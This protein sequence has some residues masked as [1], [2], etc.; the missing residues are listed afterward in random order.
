MTTFF[1]KQ[2][3]NFLSILLGMM[4]TVLAACAVL[5]AYMELCLPDVTI[6]NDA[7][8]QVPLRVYTADGKLMAEYGA[9]RRAPVP[10][11]KIPKQLIE[12]VLATE[13]ARFYSHPGVDLIGI[14]RAAI[15]VVSTGRKVQGA[16]TIT[17][18]V[19]RNFF[20]TRKKTYSR[21][22][23]EILLAIKI[24]S[25]LSKEKIL[26]LYLNKVYFG[27][28]AYGVAAA[29]HVYYGKSLNKLTLPEI[30]MIAG[31]P[32]A[33]SRNN[34]L[35]NLENAL[36]RRNHVLK[37]MLEVG[38][39]N[40]AT[41]ENAIQTP[42]TAKYHEE[43]VKVH[44]PYV[45][46][47]VRQAMV[48][49]YGARAYDSGLKV[50]TTISS[51][52]QDDATQA[53]QS[54]LIAYS[55]RHG[56]YKSTINL[57]LPSDQNKLL[58]K[59]WLQN[60][61]VIDGLQEGVVLSAN[62]QALTA[63]L[64]DGTIATIPWDGLSWAAPALP[65]GYKGAR[66]TKASDIAAPGDVIY[67]SYLT[68]QKRWQL[69]QIP[70]VQGAIV[71]LNPQNGAILALQGGFDF[72]M[73]PFNR[74]LQAERQPGSSFKPFLYSAA[75][76]KGYTLASTINDAPIMIRDTGENAWWRPENDTQQFY[77][78]T[79][80]RVALAES[81]NL[82]SIR[83]LRAIGIPYAID[84]VQRFGFDPEKLPHTLSLALGSGV[85][86]P[87][88]LTTG[89][90]VFAN[91]G[92]HVKPFFIEKIIEQGN[93]V[94]YQT[95]PQKTTQSITP[96]NAYLITQGLRAVVQSGT[97]SAAKK[98]NRSDLAGKTGT[99]NDQIDAWFA[100]F[101]SNLLATVWVGFDN[102]EQSLREYGAQAALPIWMQFMQ[103][104]LANQ[105]TAT[106][107]QPAGIVTARIDPQ[108][109][110]L[111]SST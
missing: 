33:P 57:G 67:L 20:L 86:T 65:G 15:V 73:S 39:I 34:P 29:A 106:L 7:P 102:H 107:Q 80:L 82:V 17:M 93:Q 79:R 97:A 53:L 91:G 104:A 55:N 31:L 25:V 99:T 50:I 60:Q 66:P 75:F 30:A 14:A 9:K 36:K 42:S 58:W 37:R 83:L 85:L 28:R 62:G 2:V 11:D 74:V 27:N 59:T 98:L 87:M 12:A 52:L 84:Y 76:A 22:I 100:G 101:N 35:N 24:D 18:Q 96:Q 41:Y 47:M 43:R 10:I 69:S 6:L 103:A 13:D 4:L 16:S 89:Y 56:Y 21:K 54:G 71:V 51:S 1:K 110:L 81:R 19:A 40:K 68:D 88:Q 95:T 26:E 77:G 108:T 38:Y 72:Q 8:M 45:A 90:A 49:M 5:Y 61:P 78:P 23:K 105:P 94:L 44:A 111:A 92:S 64:G 63:L 48:M 32:Q 70:K 3:G 46:E 109:G